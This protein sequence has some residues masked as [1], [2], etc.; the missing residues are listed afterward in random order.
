M[1]KKTNGVNYGKTVPQRSRRERVIKMLEVQLKSGL[2]T[3]KKR[4][5]GHKIPLTEKDI[6]RINKELV[7][8]KARL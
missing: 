3:E 6:N 5:D 7:T 2:K 4:N 1:S 8:L